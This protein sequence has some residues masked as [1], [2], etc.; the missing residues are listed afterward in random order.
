[1]HCYR[2][3]PADIQRLCLVTGD[4]FDPSDV[5]VG[6][7]A[8]GGGVLGLGSVT[9]DGGRV[10]GSCFTLSS[11]FYVFKYFCLL[12]LLCLHSVHCAVC[13]EALGT[14][15]HATLPLISRHHRNV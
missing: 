3:S 12:L 7:I 15:L 10:G 8:G 9:C 4:S 1:V 11:F 13:Y 2:V 14:K 5:D 6:G